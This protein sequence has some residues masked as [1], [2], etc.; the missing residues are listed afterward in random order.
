VR[1]RR[2]RD[3]SPVHDA[4]EEHML[5][6]KTLAVALTALAASGGSVALADINVSD[7]RRG[8]AKCNRKPCPDLRSAVAGHGIF[9]ENEQFFIVVQHS[10]VDRKRLPRLAVNTSGSNRSAPEFYVEKRASGAGVFNAKTGRKVS[11][12]VWRN[13]RRVSATW[14]FL[15]SAIGSPERY[16]WRI[17]VKAKGGSRID[18]T[19][20][21]GY[22]EHRVG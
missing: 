16:G 14:T 8:D 3:A 1:S 13:T 5:A 17:E 19:P 6:T 4:K 12:A 2:R 9:N 10:A 15:P 7:D 21:S 18:S 20:N 11:E 22:L